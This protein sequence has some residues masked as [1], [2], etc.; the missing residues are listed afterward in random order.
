MKKKLIISKKFDQIYNHTILVRKGSVPNVDEINTMLTEM[1]KA[2]ILQ[3]LWR[4]YG[5]VGSQ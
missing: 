1:K 5:L 2:G 3:N 4:K